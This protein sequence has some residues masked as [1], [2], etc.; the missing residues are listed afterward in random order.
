MFLANQK[1]LLPMKKVFSI[2]LSV[3]ALASFAQS[4]SVGSDSITVEKYIIN[5]DTISISNK[6]MYA[7]TDIF[8]TPKKENLYFIPI[9][10]LKLNV[11]SI[12]LNSTKI[13]SWTYNDTL[14]NIKS[15]TP[16]SMAGTSHLKIFYHGHPQTDPSGMG[17]FYFQSPFAYSIGVGIDANPHTFGRCWFPCLD[18]FTDKAFYEFKVLTDTTQMAVCNGTL[19]DSSL[20]TELNKKFWH[21][22]LNAKIPTYLASVAVAP[23]VCY[24]DTFN[25]IKND[26]PINIYTTANLY[27]KISGTFEDLKKMLNS[28]EDKFGPYEWER[29]GFVGVPFI[30]G[31]MEHA[32]NI[33]FPNIAINGNKTFESVVYHELSHSWFG[34]LVTC[35]TAEEMWINEGWASFC[36]FITSETL[37]GKTAME[38]NVKNTLVNVL[39]KAHLE[40]GGFYPVGNVPHNI[41]YGTTVYK[42][43]ALVVHT[44]RNYMGDTIF[45]PAVK[46]YLDSLKFKNASNSQLQSVLSHYSGIDLSSFFNDW[47]LTEGF[48][49]FDV[50]SMKS[51]P[52]G[53]NFTTTVYLRQR[54]YGRTSFSNNNRVELTFLDEHGNSCN[55]TA[56]FSGEFDTN[57]FD[58]PF[59]PTVIFVDKDEKTADAIIS[60]NKIIKTSSSN[61]FSNASTEMVVS[62]ISDSMILRVEMHKVAPDPVKSNPNI[63][64]IS[65]SRYWRISGIIPENSQYELKFNYN[66][67]S[68]FLDA[69]LILTNT[70]HDSLI[71]LYRKSPA[72][73]WEITPFT[74]TGNYAMGKLASTNGKTGEY[75]LGIGEPN[76]SKAENFIKS[77]LKIYPNPATDNIYIDNIDAECSIINITDINGKLVLS[78]KIN[79][80]E[81]STHFNT[82]KL[83]AGIFI[84]HEIDSKGNS[85]SQSKFVV[86]K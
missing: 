60:Y 71:L 20:N 48:P 53:S 42:K 41:T 26:I 15:P 69:D 1:I 59:N 49:H 63:Y 2:F 56:F 4:K 21:W 17:G 68:P 13:T 54:L 12:F 19:I 78:K 62:S 39:Q 7:H 37:H 29:V 32:T 72:Y 80:R 22:K 73:D 76:Q 77:A 64:R 70:S 47:V 58:L 50:D 84:L 55:R 27:P 66:K 11:D 40:D 79:P 75:A 23:Y 57:T 36:E 38:D 51:I 35:A 25:G 74:K 10:L 46:G 61:V 45:F 9:D 30:Y 82:E 43:G 33:A 44:L 28:Y 16:L 6:S 5:I 18:N 81:N 86:K 8:F 14:L 85:I 31:A 34:N 3:M 67:T 52:N 83:N 24:T 65:K